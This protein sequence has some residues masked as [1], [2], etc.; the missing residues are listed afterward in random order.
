MCA[1]LVKQPILALPAHVST[2]PVDSDDFAS[3]IV[4]WVAQGR[5]GEQEDFAGPQTMPITEIAEQY[6]A[7]NGLRRQIRRAP[8]PKKL[9]AAIT[10]GNTAPH[11]R[12]GTTTWA[13]WL[14][15]RHAVEH[16]ELGLAA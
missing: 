12:L 10:A 16:P 2:A 9:Q 7:A 3:L 13:Q 11:A 1:N 5:R 6:L 4:G 8:L 15:R 14:K